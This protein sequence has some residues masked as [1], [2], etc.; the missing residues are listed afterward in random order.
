MFAAEMV[1]EKR[2]AAGYSATT[3]GAAIGVSPRHLRRYEA[4][5][6]DPPLSIAGEM[7]RVLGVPLDELLVH[8]GEPAMREAPETE[9]A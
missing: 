3:F 1:K 8:D 4:G 2:K 6:I 9:C 7:A 5:D